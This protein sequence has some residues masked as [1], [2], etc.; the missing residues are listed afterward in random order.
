[1][2]PITKFWHCTLKDEQS[3]NSPL[4]QKL[5]GDILDLT[6]SYPNP[7]GGTPLMHV[8]YQDINSP[9]RLFMITGYQSQELNTEADGVYAEKYLP[10]MFEYVQHIWLRQ[11][12]LDVTALS[13]G[14][15]VVLACGK[16]PSAWKDD[17]ALG[18]WDVWPDT[19]QAQKNTNSERGTRNL[20]DEHRVWV[21]VSRWEDGAVNSIQP[22]E[23]ER[24]LLQKIA[25]K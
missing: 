17:K 6:S 13:L 19:R 20:E 15:Q 8:L 22:T 16:N 14:E 10:S 3:I 2:P 1:M 7:E 12:D 5:V 24:I 11:L 21:Q 23:G 18:G 25:G 9:S 4:F